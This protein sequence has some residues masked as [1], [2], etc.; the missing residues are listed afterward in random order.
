M[1]PS[2]RNILPPQSRCYS[3]ISGFCAQQSCCSSTAPV[4]PSI[5]SS[6]N[7]AFPSVS[8]TTELL[9]LLHAVFLN[10]P[11]ANNEPRTL[12]SGQHHWSTLPAM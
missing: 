11:I 10:N 3:T 12:N 6:V 2:S 7:T 5:R 1:I 9:N 4:V 8:T